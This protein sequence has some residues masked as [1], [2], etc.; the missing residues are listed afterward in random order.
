MLVAFGAS[1]PVAIYHTVKSKRVE[2]KSPYFMLIVSIGYVFGILAHLADGTKL[3]LCS[4][5]LVN[6]AMVLT[7]LFLYFHYSRKQRK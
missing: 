6:M 5:Y 1:W 7:D 4:V 3:W 2:G